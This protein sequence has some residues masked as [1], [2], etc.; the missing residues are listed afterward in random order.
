VCFF[1]LFFLFWYIYFI[2]IFRGPHNSPKKKKKAFL[3][4]SSD[5]SPQQLPRPSRVYIRSRLAVAENQRVLFVCEN[6]ELSSLVNCSCR[7]HHH[8]SLSLSRSLFEFLCFIPATK[9]Q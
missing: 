2:F 1:F 9:R 8:L 7:H 6:C 4:G 5:P 3:F